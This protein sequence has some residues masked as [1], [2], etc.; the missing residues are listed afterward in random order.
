MYN[1][2]QAIGATPTGV[3][4]NTLSNWAAP[5]VTNMLGQGQALANA[6]YQAYTGPLS[7]GASGLQEQAFQG[8]ANLTVPT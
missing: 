4:M 7:A 8:I 6:P 1:Q 5:Y 2:T 3:S